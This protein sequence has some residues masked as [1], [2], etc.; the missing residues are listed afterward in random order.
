LVH[1]GRVKIYKNMPTFP[2]DGWPTF[3]AVGYTKDHDMMHRQPEVSSRDRANGARG[4]QRGGRRFTQLKYSEAVAE[5]AEDYGFELD[6]DDTHD[7][8]SNFIQR[9]G[10]SDYDFIKGLSNLTGFYFWV[11]GDEQ[12]TWTLHFKDPET[13]DSGQER[14]FTLEY[15]NGNFSTL[16]S[17]EPEFLITG[18]VTRIRARVRN[19][20]TGRIM[21][22]EFTEDNLDA[23]DLAFEEESGGLGFDSVDLP[24]I[25]SAPATSTAVQLFIGDYS[26]EDLTS[27]RFGTEAELINWAR[28]W[29]RRQRENFILS[30]GVCIGV[31]D[32]MCRQVHTISGVGTVYDGDYFFSRV[33]HKMDGEGQ[34][35]TL[36]FNCRKQTPRVA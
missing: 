18:A 9:A 14:I 32:I 13:F 31:E 7:E 4:S 35:Y 16:F 1:V 10:M 2:Q 34:G 22:A 25:E 6:I 8:P 17:F 20:R 24:E 12:G 27:R 21:E 19:A 3:E 26:F 11:D 33:K 29:F 23:P 30:R 5:R 28:Q 36:D 15:N